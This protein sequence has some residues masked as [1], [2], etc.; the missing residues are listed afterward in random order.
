[1]TQTWQNVWKKALGGWLV[2][3][4]SPPTEAEKQKYRK[5]LIHN[6]A[7]RAVEWNWDKPD[8]IYDFI[9]Q[10]TPKNGY[11][12]DVTPEDIFQYSQ[13]HY[14]ELLPK[15]TDP[16]AQ[17]RLDGLRRNLRADQPSPEFN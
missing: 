16:E 3:D 10:E 12:W 4:G 15:R 1:M 5:D 13:Q 7:A 6:Q 9:R 14:A 17:T 2:G 8:Q 11:L